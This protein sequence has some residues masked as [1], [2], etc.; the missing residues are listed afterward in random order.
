MVMAVPNPRW[1]RGIERSAEVVLL[2]LAGLAGAAALT[3]LSLPA[4]ALVGSVVGAFGGSRLLLALRLHAGR[5]FSDNRSSVN[6][7]RGIHVIGQVI[8]GVVAGAQL[9]HEG[10]M[11]LVTAL[12]LILVSVAIVL[13]TS[14]IMARHLVRR[15]NVQPVTAIVATAP[16]GLSELA[17]SAQSRGADI[18]IVLL[19]HVVRVLVVVLIALPLVLLLAV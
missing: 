18:S 1:R 8:L 2:L 10:L 5:D 17:A 9:S 6:V 11:A 14:L 13:L 3:L 19:I 15:H 4:G 16:G 7:P 12:P